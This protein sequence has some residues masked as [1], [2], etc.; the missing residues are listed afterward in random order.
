MFS[1]IVMNLGLRQGS[2]IIHYIRLTVSGSSDV[3]IWRVRTEI[4]NTHWAYD[5]VATLNQRRNNVVCPVGIFIMAV[6]P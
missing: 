4:I 2:T 6:N 1:N 3:I 5:V